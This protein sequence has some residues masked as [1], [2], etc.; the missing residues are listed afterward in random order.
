[1]N[2]D[3]LS[4]SFL[5]LLPV[6][7]NLN[8]VAAPGVA[9]DRED[10]NTKAGESFRFGREGGSELGLFCGDGGIADDLARLSGASGSALL[11]G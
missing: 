9:L 2:L 11:D 8:V 4:P 5:F 1:M 7:L 10:G 6:D 3:L